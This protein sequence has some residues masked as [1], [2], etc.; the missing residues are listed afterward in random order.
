MEKVK[1]HPL[2]I[3][4]YLNSDMMKQRDIIQP[5]AESVNQMLMVKD[6]N[7]LAFFIPTDGEERIECINPVVLKEEEATNIYKI[8][9]DLKKTFIVDVP[10]EDKEIELESP[11]ACNGETKCICKDSE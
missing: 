2:I 8:I 11:C 6:A 7:A 9:D 1:Q 10:V 3:V 4:F 5:F